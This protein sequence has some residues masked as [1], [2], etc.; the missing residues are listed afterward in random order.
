MSESPDANGPK[1]QAIEKCHRTSQPLQRRAS[2]TCM[3]PASRPLPCTSAPRSYRKK[4]KQHRE[5]RHKIK[6]I[7][8][9]SRPARILL[10]SLRLAPDS[11][12]RAQAR[13]WNIRTVPLTQGKRSR[14]KRRSTICPRT[15]ARCARPRPACQALCR[16]A[17]YP[18]KSGV[19][20]FHA[21]AYTPRAFLTNL[22][23]NPACLYLTA[24][25]GP[26]FSRSRRCASNV[27]TG[28]KL[29]GSVPWH[30][31]Y[32]GAPRPALAAL[33][34]AADACLG[35][36]SAAAAAGRRREVHGEAVQRVPLRGH[37]QAQGVAWPVPFAP[38]R[39]LHGGWH[40]PVHLLPSPCR[41][42]WLF[43]ELA[44]PGEVAWFL[45]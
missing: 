8:C 12:V 18:A 24:L 27:L 41:A 28:P 36:T 1:R 29:D 4:L 21:P 2:F 9:L 5:L 42:L 14:P 37:T 25:P 38:W 13:A 26:G 23:A 44:V 17:R 34:W 22:L 19:S 7:E 39:A 45:W 32:E 11:D 20:P 30:R 3:P 31:P 43:P 6:A 33:L 35:G 40:A 10:G 16:R 15:T